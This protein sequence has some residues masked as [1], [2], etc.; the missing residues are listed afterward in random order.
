MR[1]SE[2]KQNGS[3]KM[4]KG[5]KVNVHGKGGGVVKFSRSSAQSRDLFIHFH[6][7]IINQLFIPRG[8]D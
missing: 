4:F 6:N 3:D 7:S 1:R 8:E 2:R 5:E